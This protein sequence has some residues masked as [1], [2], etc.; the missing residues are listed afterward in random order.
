VSK[1]EISDISKT[2]S[3]V[4]QAI[5]CKPEIEELRKLIDKKTSK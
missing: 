4:V 3:E 5:D 1:A 2:I